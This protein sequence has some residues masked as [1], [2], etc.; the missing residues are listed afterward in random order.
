MF[1]GT[2][3]KHKFSPKRISMHYDLS[4]ITI[5]VFHNGKDAVYNPVVV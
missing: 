2:L 5:F 4:L 1:P 3:P